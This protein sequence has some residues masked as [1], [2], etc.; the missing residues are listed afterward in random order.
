M[1]RNAQKLDVSIIETK[2]QTYSRSYKA[3]VVQTLYLSITL[4]PML[5]T[6]DAE[7]KFILYHLQSIFSS[8]VK[9]QSQRTLRCILALHENR[10]LVGSSMPM[11]CMK[12]AKQVL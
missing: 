9:R 8:S 5:L 4:L 1:L 10:R 11:D 7:S 12:R 3:K 2:Y 6:H